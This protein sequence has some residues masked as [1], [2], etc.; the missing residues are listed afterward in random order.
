MQLAVYTKKGC[1]S[2]YTRTTKTIDIHRLTK[3]VNLGS[4]VIT[5]DISLVESSC[6]LSI[7]PKT[8]CSI[9]F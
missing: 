2:D 1:N 5:K 6:I 9:C 7:F 3:A 8:T 4:N